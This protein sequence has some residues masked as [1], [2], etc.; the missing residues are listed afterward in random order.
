MLIGAIKNG[1]THVSNFSSRIGLLSAGCSGPV[2]PFESA[3]GLA[4]KDL[5]EKDVSKID[6]KTPLTSDQYLYEI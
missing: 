5:L 4:S 2:K 3:N 6:K 1:A